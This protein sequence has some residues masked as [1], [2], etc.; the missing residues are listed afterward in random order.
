MDKSDKTPI[1]DRL[2]RKGYSLGEEKC[3]ST[4]A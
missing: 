1:I 4:G 3:K 2:K